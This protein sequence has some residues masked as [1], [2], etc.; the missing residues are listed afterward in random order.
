MRSYGGRVYKSSLISD[1]LIESA[2]TTYFL[3]QSTLLTSNVFNMATWIVIAELATY[4]GNHGSGPGL[5]SVTRTNAK[6]ANLIGVGD[7]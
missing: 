1:N 4:V 6:A 3:S 7:Y 5:I 2:K